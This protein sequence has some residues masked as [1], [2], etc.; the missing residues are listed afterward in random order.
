L[1]FIIAWLLKKFGFTAVLI[2][3][4]FF[5]FLAVGSFYAFSLQA[6][7]KLYHLD[8]D[9]LN[10]VS[11]M[12]SSGSGSSQITQLFLSILNV[13]GFL[14]ALNDSMSIITTA[15]VF[16]VSKALWRLTINAYHNI[17]MQ[18]TSVANAVS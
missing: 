16:L 11:N 3:V 4:S 18:I 10:M 9:L 15:M 7:V 14:P 2:T 1:K 6:I 5:Y 8:Q 12:G 13:S 17:V